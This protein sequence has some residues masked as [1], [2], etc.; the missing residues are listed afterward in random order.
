M[1]GMWIQYRLEALVGW[2]SSVRRLLPPTRRRRIAALT[3]SALMGLSVL[4]APLLMAA[5]AD[6]VSGGSVTYP[7]PTWAAYVSIGTG[8]TAGKNDGFC[9]GTVIS[10]RWI[11]IANHCVRTGS[12]SVRPAKEFHVIIG[13][14][15]ITDAHE[16]KE[17]SVVKVVYYAPYNAT[18]LVGDVALLE[19]DGS[20]PATAIPMPLA[21]SGYE[22]RTG[23]GVTEYGYGFQLETY[24]DDG[25]PVQKE[26]SDFLRQTLAGSYKTAANCGDQVIKQ[27]ESTV[28]CFTNK[29]DSYTAGGDSGGPWV[30]SK[31]HPFTIAVTSGTIDFHKDTR[32]YGGTMGARVADPAF[33]RWIA[34]KADIPQGVVGDIYTDRKTGEAGLFESDGFLHPI[35][36]TGDDAVYTCLV[37][38]GHHVQPAMSPFDFAEYPENAASPAA[39]A[40][41][42]HWKAV[43]LPLPGNQ[44]KSYPYPTISNLACTTGATTDC[45]AVGYYSNDSGDLLAHP[46]IDSGSGTSWTSI[47][48]PVPGNAIDDGAGTLTAVACGKTCAAIGRY[49][50]DSGSDGLIEGGSRGSWKPVQAPVNRADYTGYLAVVACGTGCV[51]AGNQEVG[52]SGQ[53]EPLLERGSGA[54]WT[55]SVGSLPANALKPDSHFSFTGATCTDATCLVYGTYIDKNGLTQGLVETDS[56][57]KWTA[58][59]VAYPKSTGAGQEFTPEAA[60]CQ[61]TTRCTLVGIYDSTE[62]GAGWTAMDTGIKGSWAAVALPI[63]YVNSPLNSV[64]CPSA[65]SCTATGAFLGEDGDA[66]ILAVTGEGD[67]WTERYAPNPPHSGGSTGGVAFPEISG[68]LSCS[69]AAA[70]VTVGGYYATSLTSWPYISAERGGKW[71]TIV[72]PVPTPHTGDPN[73]GLTS[74]DCADANDCVALGTYAIPTPAGQTQVG[75]F[76]ELPY[77]AVEVGG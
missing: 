77:V 28:I 58:G 76:W 54:S 27:D 3:L 36:V 47:V 60:A 55:A 20:F 41:A 32:E 65:S 38:A 51:A 72:G 7:T 19:I 17:Y 26:R 64:T 35:P 49:S 34:E 68:T 56:D 71:A 66:S 74:V 59:E 21:P 40:Q 48:A 42:T 8:V 16:G 67:K 53:F 30:T 73:A 39:C 33:H 37:E 69:S 25:D 29:G 4:A 1:L 63:R 43:R 70:C 13:R 10:A 22:P 46:F 15:D 6:A 9:T 50:P 18:R 31:L 14:A 75:G 62:D 45:A 61:S 23:T 57:G 52:G 44:S 2:L 12:D 5:P 11:L 24:N